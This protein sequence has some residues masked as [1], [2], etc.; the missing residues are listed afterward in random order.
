MHE[1]INYVFSTGIDTGGLQVKNRILLLCGVLVMM[2]GLAG[3]ASKDKEDN[4]AI[5]VE[6]AETTTDTEQETN[7]AENEDSDTTD[8]DANTNTDEVVT[9]DAETE[10]TMVYEDMTYT[11]GGCEYTISSDW[12]EMVIDET[13]KN[14]TK[15]DAAIVT[16][17]MDVRG[18][19]TDD[20]IR[21]TYIDSITS[22]MDNCIITDETELTIADKDAYCY[23]FTFRVNDV[24][25]TSRLVSFDTNKGIVTFILLTVNETGDTYQAVLDTILN[26]ITILE[27]E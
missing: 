16:S 19:I 4:N 25:N 8:I 2:L 23:D 6:K 3:C 9:P 15:K 20:T 17:F 21:E 14:Y 22:A 26:S 13:Q 11:I 18:S 7:E 27:N 12:V 1:D 5:T 10:D 24:E